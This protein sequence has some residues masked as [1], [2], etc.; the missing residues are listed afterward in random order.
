MQKIILV[1]DIFGESHWTDNFKAH[2]SHQAKVFI[3]TPY[4][5]RMTF[6]G[7]NEA[8]KAF[9][10]EGGMD[11]YIDKVASSLIN[12][13]CTNT[14]FLGFSAGAAAL[15]KVLST[16][17]S[18]TGDNHFIGFYPGQIRH[19]LDVAPKC[20]CSLI[21]PS[22]EAHFDLQSVINQLQNSVNGK[23][24]QNELEHGFI[25]PDSNNFHLQA[26][27]EVLGWSE[28]ISKLFTA[29]AFSTL[30]TNSAVKYTS[31]K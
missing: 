20:R 21:F 15:W 29:N 12:I 31:I 2:V 22:K 30:M 24:W 17:K 18:E 8:Y 28:N 23:I 9:I 3:L 26:S 6:A 14:V 25:N 4:S 16:E 13:N 10:E 7:E 1:T 27:Q 19:F 11:A 5:S